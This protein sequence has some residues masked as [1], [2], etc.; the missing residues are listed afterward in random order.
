MGWEFTADT[1][2]GHPLTGADG[3]KVTLSTV[4]LP[5]RASAG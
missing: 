1:V 5:G 3:G 2:T 4:S